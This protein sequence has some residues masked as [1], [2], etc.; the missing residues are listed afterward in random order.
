MTVCVALCTAVS[1]A[2]GEK[3]CMRSW[4]MVDA[5]AAFTDKVAGQVGNQTH[6]YPQ[7]E[8]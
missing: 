4:G 7:G 6:D 1:E 3:M 8:R 2:K 5:T